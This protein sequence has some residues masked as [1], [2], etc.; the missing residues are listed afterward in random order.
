MRK[1]IVSEFV[2]LDGV[3]EA[4]NLWSF[5]FASEEQEKY[6]FDELFASD[7][8]LLGRETYEGFAAAWPTMPGTGEFGERMNSIQKYVFSTTLS[9]VAWNNTRQL[10]GSLAAE[11]SELKRQAGQD[12]VVFGSGN[13]VHQL[14][15]ENLVDEYRVMIFPIIVGS[16]KRL[17][18]EGSK[19]KALKLVETQTFSSGVV[20]LTYHSRE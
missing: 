13:L 2:T 20:V 4:P 11:V 3:I 18:Q 5:Q 1:I 19:Q 16:G 8:I 9:E 6:K 14:T 7:A 15:Q 17:F 12:I 10:K